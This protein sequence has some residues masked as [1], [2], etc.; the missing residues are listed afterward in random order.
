MFGK[1]LNNIYGHVQFQ[2]KITFKHQ[3]NAMFKIYSKFN[4][5]GQS[6]ETRQ[7]IS[8]GNK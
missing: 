5:Q 8:I 1:F 6:I 2:K 4:Q 3:T 7:L